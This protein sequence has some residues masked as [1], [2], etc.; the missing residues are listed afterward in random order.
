MFD[1]IDA[2]SG[3]SS[4]NLSMETHY[5]TN[6]SLYI[7]V[8]Q[9][10]KHTAWYTNVGGQ[11]LHCEVLGSVVVLLFTII[12]TYL[13]VKLCKHPSIMLRCCQTGF[14]SCM[15]KAVNG[16]KKKKKKERE[17]NQR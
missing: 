17:R 3:P 16:K 8:K 7:N 10:L 4:C 2:K 6:L 9:S 13:E 15:Y 14:M 12:C 1:C 11:H 5:V